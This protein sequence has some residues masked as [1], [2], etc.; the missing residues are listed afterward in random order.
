LQRSG[1]FDR[2]DYRCVYCGE[3]F[4]ADDLTIDHVQPRVRGGDH[5]GGNLVTAC[6]ACNTLKG[7][8]R[9]SQFLHDN[10]VARANFARYAVHVWPRLMRLLDDELAQLDAGRE[11]IR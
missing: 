5:S 8:R 10:L 3:R 4:A 6:R 9:L 2:D 1:I 11:K 7:H